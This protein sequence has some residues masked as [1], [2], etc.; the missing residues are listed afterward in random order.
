MDPTGPDAAPWPGLAGR[1]PRCL[2]RPEWCLCAEIP[3]LVTRTR[4]V[5]V[6]HHGERFRSSNTGRLAHLALTNSELHDVG[7]HAR[8]ELDDLDPAAWL[9]FPEGEPCTRAPEPPPAT[10]IALDATWHQARRLR[11]RLPA[12]RGR[13]M[14]ALAPEPAASRM[15]KAPVA[16]HVSTIE[17]IAAV[18]R[19]LG[20]GAAADQ[21]D[22]LF[23]VAIDRQRQSGRQ[24]PGG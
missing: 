6:R 13:R 19:L 7:G 24:P 15:R 23:A 22:R 8:L 14:L 5:I 18:L 3:Q 9:L 20:D 12:L 4:I 2:H 1:C 10:V 11:Q 21:L 17:A 16:T